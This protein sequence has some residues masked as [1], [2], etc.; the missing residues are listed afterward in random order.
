MDVQTYG[1][2]GRP[3]QGARNFDIQFY[4]AMKE[5]NSVRNLSP[6]PVS[7]AIDESCPT[8]TPQSADGLRRGDKGF[9][10]SFLTIRAAWRVAGNANSVI[11][12]GG[13][14]YYDDLA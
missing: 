9:L 6:H 12:I 4:A 8:A 10:Q 1:T 13:F 11:T 5:P 3:C 2:V 14:R 7:T